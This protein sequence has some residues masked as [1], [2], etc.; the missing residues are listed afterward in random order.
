MKITAIVT[1]IAISAVS[2]ECAA[3]RTDGKVNSLREKKG[4]FNAA[5]LVDKL[6]SI[7]AGTIWTAKSEK[8][9]EKRTTFNAEAL[10]K[11]LDSVGA[12]KIWGVKASKRSDKEDEGFEFDAESVIKK[13]NSIGADTIWGIK[14]T[15]S[16]DKE[17]RAVFE[18][19]KV[20]R[21]IRQR[22]RDRRNGRRQGRNGRGW[23]NDRDNRRE[24]K[25][26]Q[27]Q[28]PEATGAPAMSPKQEVI[29]SA[30][31]GSEP[32]DVISFL[33]SVPDATYEQIFDL[34]T[35]QQFMAAITELQQKRTPDL[36][37]IRA[38]AP[39]PP[40][41]AAG[42]PATRRI[43]IRQVAN[44]EVP[45][46][47]S[48]PNQAAPDQG[49]PN[50]GTPNQGT[51]DQGTANQPATPKEDFIMQAKQQNAP[52]NAITFLE[53]VPDDVYVNLYH[54]P[55]GP[56]FEAAV[57]QLVQG[58]IPT[59]NGTAGNDPAATNGN[60]AATPDT[61]AD[62]GNQGTPGADQNV[63]PNQGNPIRK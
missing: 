55:D 43:K 44:Q 6:D 14:S 27:A 48:T 11:K 46:Q 21:P 61:S 23:R 57:Q 10:T 1:T 38:S 28:Q 16:E 26:R 45:T 24:I 17:K 33:Q 37:K 2:V 51:P 36:N 58:Q 50:Q 4:T 15:K 25:A 59:F 8:E 29:Q 56:E 34:P 47:D 53:G 42:A 40:P 3:I 32:A 13:L 22:P 19:E 18:N 9:V 62:Q 30:Q 63:V 60:T 52:P 20:K 35:D 5:A 39:S 41:A 54:L 49:T 31:A 7:G 12:D